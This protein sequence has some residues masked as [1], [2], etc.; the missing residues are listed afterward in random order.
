MILP[1]LAER[2]KH[3]KGEIFGFGD[4]QNEESEYALEN[5]DTEKLE[6][7]PIHNLTAERSVG[8][9]NYE[10]QRRGA[11]QLACASS[12]QV[13]SMS[14]DLIDTQ[15]SGSYSKYTKLV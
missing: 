10:L 1:K 4:N 9:I 3:Q 6:K 14:V 7:A 11:K 5:M 12:A 13:K 2:F 8:F 15:P